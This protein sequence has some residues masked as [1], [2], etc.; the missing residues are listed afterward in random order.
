M[1]VIGPLIG[2]LC[3]TCDNMARKISYVINVNRKVHSLTTLLEEL[4]Y[5]RDDIQRQV[6]CAELKGLICTCQVQGWLERVKDVETKAS[7]ITGVLG[8]RKQCFMCCVANSCTRYKLSKRVS[9]LQMEINEL[10]GKGAFDAVIADGLVSET[11]QEMPIRPSVGLNMMVEKVQQF[12]AEDEVGIIGIYGMG[13]IG[14]TTLLKSINN[15]FLTKSHE[16]EV[17]IWAVVSKDFIVDNI[18]QA[19][20]ARLGLSWEECEGR[21][22]RVWKIYRVMKSKKF[23]LLLD[24]VWEGI[25]LQQIGIPLPNKE[26]KCKVIFTTRSLDVCSDLDAHRKLKVEILG[27]EDSWKLFCDKMAGREILEWE[28]IRPYAETIV[29]KCG[30]LPLALITIGKAMANKETEEEW[31]YAV[32]ILNRYPSEIRGMEDVFTLLKFS[33]DNLETDTLRSCFLYCALYPEDY[34]IDKE[35]LIEYWI[36]EGFLDSNVHNKGHAIIGSLKVAC[37]LETGEE[38]TQVKMHDV[39]R[40][41]ALWIAT[42]CG[43]NKGLILVEASM[44]LTAV[45]DAERWN[46]AQRVSLMDNGITTLAEVP[47]C[48]NLLTLLLQYNSGLSRIPDTYFLLMPSLRVLDLSLTSLRELPASIN[49][50]VELQHLDLSGTKITALPKELGHLSKLKHLDLQR[51]TS[52]RTI[53]QQALSGLLQLRVLNFYYSYAGWGGNNSETAKEVGFADL[54]C[55]KHLTTLGITIKES[56]MLKKLGIFSSLLNTIQYLYIKECKRLFCLQISSNTSYGK[57]LRRLSINNCYDLKYL[58]VDEEAGDKWLL[59]LE[60]LALHGLPSLVVVWK[61]PVT[62]ECLQNLR[63]VNIWHCHKL[64]EVSWVFQLQ[65]LEFLYL[66]Y[67]N[68]MEE[69]VSRENMPMEAPKAFPSLKTLSI[70]NLPKLRSIAQRALAFPTLETIAVIDCPKLKMLP[71]KTHSTLT[72]PTVYGSKEW[73]D[74]L[75]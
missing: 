65:N 30:G 15:K 27:K 46:G 12:L 68:E 1:E 11:V 39:V 38:K 42:E 20:G 3:S 13:G 7:L 54:E 33:Y 29:R 18:Q 24:D 52:L 43:L 60:V 51:A 44:G 74:G 5:K 64:K 66:M 10:I 4:K 47:D 53:P 63:S 41:F 23:L 22:Q 32:E 73:W 70:R 2:I 69:V 28:S 26:N 71:I 37:L 14:K 56:K 75:E 45:P 31:R 62:R 55:L 21:E 34:S 49:R 8:Q 59:S 17:V 50:L 72:L 35:Q 67:C 58:E 19:V 48:P 36:G 9:E 40:S 6:D 57:N 61:N 16:F 25:D